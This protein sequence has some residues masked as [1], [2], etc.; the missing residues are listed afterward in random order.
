VLDDRGLGDDDVTI[1]VA[2]L[3]NDGLV[4]AS[5]SATTLMA[6]DQR[7]GA[8]A[9]LN[10]YNNANKVFNLHKGSPL[11]A[12]TFG[13]GNI[14]DAS[15]ALLAKEFRK[16]LAEATP[17]G[18][19]AWAFNPAAYTI[20]E[21]ATAFRQFMF[22]DRYQAAF[23]SATKKPVLGFKV[24]G[25]STGAALPELWSIKVDET[26]SC[27]AP[28][29]VRGPGDFGV[30]WDGEPEALQRLLLGIPTGLGD[31]LVAIGLPKADVQKAIAAL[32]PRLE[33][34]MALGAMPL[35]D[36][37][38]LAEYLVHTTIMFSKFK[39]GAPTV[40]GPIEIAAVTKHEGFKWVRRKHYYPADL[41]PPQ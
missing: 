21:V 30:N 14:G 19:S 23:A 9:V 20:E 28:E 35:Q 31:G 22:E 12:Y 10:V 3:V 4:L 40:G 32:K 13:A 41:N 11:G 16:Q 15:I 37:I 5:D 8:T 17:I 25:F 18:L 38:D 7:T 1:A 2:V 33:I 34:A 24:G 26:G 27:G 39:P 29:R 36:A 6:T